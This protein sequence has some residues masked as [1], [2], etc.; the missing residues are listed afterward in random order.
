MISKIWCSACGA[1]LA[2]NYTDCHEFACLRQAPARQLI[3]G[4]LCNPRQKNN[5]KQP[6]NY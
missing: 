1:D 3:R 4:N 6:L 2:T 5:F